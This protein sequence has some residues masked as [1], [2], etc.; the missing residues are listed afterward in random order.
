MR[1]RTV[2]DKA[3]GGFGMAMDP[4]QCCTKTALFLLKISAGG[5]FNTKIVHTGMELCGEVR[6]CVIPRINRGMTAL[7]TDAVSTRSA[8]FEQ[9]L[10]LWLL[11][12]RSE[13][14]RVGKECR[15]RW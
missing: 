1:L 11:H 4:R 13:E 5:N 7:T 3:A 6:C 9:H 12:P 15:S 14:R 10:F 8:F 2:F